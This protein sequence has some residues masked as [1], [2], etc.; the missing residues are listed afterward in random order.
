M[1]LILRYKQSNFQILTDYSVIISN[2]LLTVNRFDKG[3][4]MVTLFDITTSPLNFRGLVVHD[5]LSYVDDL[6]SLESLIIKKRMIIPKLY[7]IITYNMSLFEIDTI[8]I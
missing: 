7:V 2:P 1:I 5:N 8:I 6:Y 3:R 4:T